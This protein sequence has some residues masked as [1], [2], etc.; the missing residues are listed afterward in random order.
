VHGFV[1]QKSIVTN[2]GKHLDR[3][4]L[5]NFDLEDFFP[6]LHFG[7]VKGLYEGR[8]YFL[9]EQVAVTLAQI[10]CHNGVL[11]IGAPTSPI[12]SN[13]VCAQMDSQQKRLASNRLRLHIYEICG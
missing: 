10:C 3:D 2:A 1:R 5:L 12:V 9:P 7:R 11:P 8:P 13:M 4:T 6:T